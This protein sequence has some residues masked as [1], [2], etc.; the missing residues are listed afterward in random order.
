MDMAAARFEPA[1]P[2]PARD[3][4]PLFQALGDCVR[5]DIRCV[6]DAP[7]RLGRLWEDLASQASE[8]NVFAESF[9]CGPA[10]RHLAPPGLRMLEAWAETPQGPLLLGLLPLQI[11]R[12]YGRVPVRHVQNWLHFHS[13]LG[14]PLIRAG[15]EEAVWKGALQALDTDAGA[16]GF[17]HIQ[18]LGADGPAHRG[19]IAAAGALGRRCDTVHSSE[20]AL[21]A[22]GLSP[23]EYYERTVRKKKRKELKR[24]S[25]RLAALGW[26][27][28]HTLQRA[29][30]LESWCDAFLALERSGWKGEAGSALTCDPST[31]AFFREAAAGAFASGRLDLLRL[32]LDGRPIAMLV[33]LLAPPG[34]FSFKIAYDEELSRFSPGV[35]IQIENLRVLERSDIAWMDSCAVENHPMINSLWAERRRIVR[36]TVPL[37]GRRRGL[38]FRASRFLEDASAAVRRR[39]GNGRNEELNDDR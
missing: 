14:T 12:K 9:F 24:L 20:R 35:L 10:I 29:E 2:A 1:R 15:Y 21:L 31:D 26:V 39:R 11:A 25:G 28:F 18:G 19:L 37:A 13:F 27:E 7:Q 32:D 8:P 22:S 3:T 6:A 38:E 17:L 16:P 23:T 36:V 34:S 5:I 33:N 4:K 30:D